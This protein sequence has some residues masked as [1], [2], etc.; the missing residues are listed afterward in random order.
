MARRAYRIL[1]VSLLLESGQASF[2]ETFDLDYA[3]FALPSPPPEPDME[4]SPMSFRFEAGPGPAF[5]EVDGV[6]ES[7]EG[8]P[9]PERQAHYDLT[10]IIMARVEAYTVLHAAVLGA[11]G[12]ALALPG[13]S[14]AGK[15]TLA[16]DL[17]DTGLAY[18]SDDFCPVHRRTFQVH[19][20][21]RSLWVRPAPGQASASSLRGKVLHPLDGRRFPVGGPPLPLSWLVCL[22][23]GEG[24]PMTGFHM[25][26]RPGM[27]DALLEDLRAETEFALERAGGEW[28]VRHPREGACVQRV[29]ELLDRHRQALWSLHALPDPL[30]DFSR[31]PHLAPIPPGEAAFFLLRQLK[32]D[33]LDRPGA[34]LHH[35]GTLLAGTAC[36]RLGPG[37]RKARLALV[38]QVMEAAPASGR[39]P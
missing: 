3:R 36:F 27:G 10:R 8:H 25:A 6:R 7:L 4:A 12:G 11:P 29:R 16:L 2:L 37:P 35:L 34:L 20:F 14:G 32:H 18:F 9:H 13:P 38:R 28:V 33:R 5:L 15:T 19:P 30:P 21:P 31:K 39:T 17:L 26:P 24:T 1:D 22:E 23:G